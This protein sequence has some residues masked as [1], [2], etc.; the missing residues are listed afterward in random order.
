MNGE[1]DGARYQRLLDLLG[2]EALAAFLAERAIDDPVARRLDDD[3]LAGAFGQLVGLGELGHHL[4]RLRQRQR[5]AARAD[6][7]LRCLQA[8]LSG[9]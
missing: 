4:A 3:E 1:I 5:R 6:T 7:D 8:V 9:C 2:E